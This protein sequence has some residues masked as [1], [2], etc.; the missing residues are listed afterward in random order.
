MVTVEAQALGV[1]CV[2]SD[3]IPDE[4]ICTNE[5]LRV[6]LDESNDVWAN[7]V[8]NDE[9]NEVKNNIE[10]LDMNNVIKK[11]KEMYTGL[12]NM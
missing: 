10:N 9:K 1:K 2:V 11:L 6:N 3:C 5:C 8:L 12:V 4:V 7:K